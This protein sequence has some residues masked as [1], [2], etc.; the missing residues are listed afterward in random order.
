MEGEKQKKD[1]D[2]TGRSVRFTDE[3]ETEVIFNRLVRTQT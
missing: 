1:V 2:I 3:S